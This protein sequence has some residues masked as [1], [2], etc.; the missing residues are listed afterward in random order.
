MWILAKLPDYYQENSI[1]WLK[2]VHVQTVCLPCVHVFLFDY[3][4]AIP[5]RAEGLL[6]NSP[7]WQ[8]THLHNKVLHSSLNVHNQTAT[9]SP[10]T[11]SRSLTERSATFTFLFHLF[12]KSTLKQFYFPFLTPTCFFSKALKLSPLLSLS[13]FSASLSLPHCLL[14][15]SLFIALL[16]LSSGFHHARCYRWTCLQLGELVAEYGRLEMSYIGTK[17][18]L[19]EHE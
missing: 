2:I 14:L 4:A 12:K 10:D 16:S 8:E 3:P 7:P 17:C 15:S 1:L 19:T 6:M 9:C 13:R 18:S 11:Y 5:F